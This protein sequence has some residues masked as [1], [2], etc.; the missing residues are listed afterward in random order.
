MDSILNMLNELKMKRY[1]QNMFNLN[2]III[3]RQTLNFESES[4][5]K[6]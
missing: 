1:F 3:I 2:S 5:L 4:M 6:F